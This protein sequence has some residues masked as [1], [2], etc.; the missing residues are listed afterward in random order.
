ML[1]QLRFQNFKSWRDTGEIR[2]APITGIFGTNS[3]GKTAI[4]QFLLMLKQTV[5]TLDSRRILHLGD[6]NTY[7]NLGTSYDIAHRHHLPT[8]I[9]YSLHWKPNLSETRIVLP[10]LQG[11]GIMAGQP[12]T[13]TVTALYSKTLNFEA[14]IQIELEKITVQEFSYRFSAHDTDQRHQSVRMQHQSPFNDETPYRLSING[15]LVQ[16]LFSL[17]DDSP[18]NS[19]SFDESPSSL[20]LSSPLKHYA[21]P[22]EI[23]DAKM[24]KFRNMMP[25][26]VL[27]YESLLQHMVYLGPLRDYP[28]RLYPWSGEKP[29]DVGKR[30][31]LA[32]AALLGSRKD[33]PEL[34]LK[35]AYWLKELKLIHGFRV[36]SIAEHRQYYEVLVKCAPDAP[37]VLITDVG[38]GISQVL[39][40]LVLCYYVPKG[41]VILLEQ[42]EIH[43]HPSVQS[44]LADM[45]IDAIKT[46]QIRII[47]ESHSEHL[48]HRLQRRI[49]EE[50]IAV[51]DAALYFCRMDETGE[52]H[53]ET[54]Q[55]DL[56]GNITNWPPNF[57]GDDM[58]DL[59]K[60]TEAAMRR[61]GAVVED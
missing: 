13:V 32:V 44:G 24:R 28:R 31:E 60:M 38:F 47:V 14:V 35:V 2:I 43:L 56:Y 40:V 3:S 11:S 58:E 29:Q 15:D 26:L 6:E 1:T 37:E 41:S 33:N 39:P 18:Y 7:I 42:P 20:A 51:E 54:L 12:S 49:A 8:E 9:S 61:Q 36:Q 21:F 30:G 59:V 50:E 25:N 45:F 17:P 10:W 19:P 57:F 55:L 34:E 5:E 23:N 4:L 27:G 52:S 48:L 22:N 46:R 16:D 53:L